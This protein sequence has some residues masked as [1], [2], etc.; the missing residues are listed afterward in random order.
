MPETSR[1][2][3]LANTP[4]PALDD[5]SALLGGIYDAAID[6][7]QWTHSLAAICRELSRASSI[8]TIAISR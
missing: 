1:A 3:L 4:A 2:N 5:F 7:A 6:P 8:R